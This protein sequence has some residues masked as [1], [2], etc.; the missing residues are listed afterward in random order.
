[1][2]ARTRSTRTDE[3]HQPRVRPQLEVQRPSRERIAITN[4][5]TAPLVPES[6]FHDAMAS[7]A[8]NRSAD[9][10][11]V[12]DSD[13]ESLP[14]SSA[15]RSATA[16]QGPSLYSSFMHNSSRAAT[17]IGKAGKGLF[18]KFTRSGSGTGDRH[19]A[20][21]PTLD[22]Y[23]FKVIDTPLVDQTRKTRIKRSLKGAGDKT[24]FW[25]PSLPY[26]CIE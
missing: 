11:A 10:H 26:R 6:G 19:G 17:G 2:L 3:T 21:T 24:E 18:G 22:N 25:M 14:A 16:A 12:I 20:T 23:V 8:R 9:R 4:P 13:E 7:Q 1:M 15:M 5:R